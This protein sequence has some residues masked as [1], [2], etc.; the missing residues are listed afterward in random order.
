MFKKAILII[1]VVLFAVC[2]NLFVLRISASSGTVYIRSDGSVD[3]SNAP[4]HRQGDLYTLDENITSVSDGLIIQRDNV[5]FD[6]QGFWFIGPGSGWNAGIHIERVI[7]IFVE[8]ASF[9]RFQWGM[10]IYGGP[11]GPTFNITVRNSNF[12]DN[13]DGLY[14]SY[15]SGGIFCGNNITDNA[16]GIEEYDATGSVFYHNNFI[17]NQVQV[18]AWLA[19][20]TEDSWDAGYP[21]GGNYWSGYNGTDLKSGKYQNETGLDGIGDTAYVDNTMMWFDV[22][23]GPLNLR[24]NYP[25]MKPYSLETTD[26]PITPELPS[27]I[28][29]LF[30]PGTLIIAFVLRWK[31]RVD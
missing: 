31:K 27:G 30:L 16:N 14:F 12:V 10:A 21:T 17:N 7:N 13:H 11:A 20:A 18:L 6:G 24:D 25:L 9:T 1:F 26:P 28:I 2:G 15:P 23:Y 8:N 29:V 3:P 22:S 19:D 5:T 4:I